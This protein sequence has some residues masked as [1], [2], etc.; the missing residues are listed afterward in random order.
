MKNNNTTEKFALKLH[1]SYGIGGRFQH[2]SC[3]AKYNAQQ[4]LTGRTYWA[5]D[6]TLSYFGAR[7]SSCWHF[8]HGLLLVVDSSVNRERCGDKAH[9][10]CTVFD[11]FGTCVVEFDD[12]KRSRLDK[13]FSEWRATF[14]ARA[15]YKAEGARKIE[16][17]RREASALAKALR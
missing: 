9:L 11:C 16:N 2:K 3:D 7:I 15:W 14:D 12:T 17:V 8:A 4:N 5:S 1:N 6:D 10:R 13:A